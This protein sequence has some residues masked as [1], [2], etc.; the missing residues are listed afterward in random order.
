MTDEYK[1]WKRNLIR[2]NQASHS[3]HL[4]EG[5]ALSRWWLALLPAGMKARC[6]RQS[7][8]WPKDYHSICQMALLGSKFDNSDF[9][10]RSQ[11]PCASRVAP[12]RMNY[13]G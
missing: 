8:L 13:K 3:A 11:A 1:S 2:F 12:E 10:K 5:R 4:K 9:C 6:C 7:A